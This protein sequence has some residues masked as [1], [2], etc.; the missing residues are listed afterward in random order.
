M[1]EY[2]DKPAVYWFKNENG[3][4]VYVGSTS[5]LRKRMYNHRWCIRKSDK[6]NSRLYQF[7]RTNLYI[8]EYYYTDNYKLREK[9]MI[10]EYN[11]EFNKSRVVAV[12]KLDISVSAA[13]NY[14]E[15]HRQYLHANKEY[16]QQHRE[17][18]RK[19]NELH[20]DYFKKWRE[21]HV[22]KEH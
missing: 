4:V 7:L 8:V 13:D 12:S 17:Y 14:N 18:C 20:R 9:E 22:N 5:N 16:N 15:Y 1:R 19:W 2:E 3:V 21:E 6:P 11:P 10:E